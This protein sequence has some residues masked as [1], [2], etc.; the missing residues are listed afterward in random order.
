MAA[1]FIPAAPLRPPAS[2]APRLSARP[3]RVARPARR[4][5][6]AVAM[7]VPDDDRRPSVGFTMYAELLNGRAAMLGFLA[8]L[9]IELATGQ[10]L[11]PT[12]LELTAQ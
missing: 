6:P 4:P 9:L 12:L 10:G 8:V 11:V 7:R 3:A 1:A 2:P 5:R